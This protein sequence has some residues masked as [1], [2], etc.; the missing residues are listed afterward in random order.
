MAGVPPLWGFVAK[1]A[2][3]GAVLEEPMLAGM[4]RNLMLVG[5]VVGSILTMAYALRF[6]YGAFA[7]KPATHPTGG[8]TSEAVD[9]MHPIGPALWLAP[10]VLNLLTVVFGFWTHPLDHA[11]GT[12]LDNVTPL[13]AGAED[14]YLALWHGFTLP[15]LLTAIIIVAGV[16]MFWQRDVVAKAQ[17]EKPALGSADHGYDLVLTFFRNIS[18]RLTAST[19]RGSLGGNLGIIFSVLILLP[20]IALF[21]GERNDVRMVLWDSPGQAI[22]SVI[23]VLAAIAATITTN[24]LSGVILVGVTGYALAML[25]ACRAPLT[26]R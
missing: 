7:T 11:I 20:G 1:E 18:L 22:A 4:P 14:T 9:K 26:W 3:L 24:R 12:H 6:L 23:I 5:L 2:A 17:F 25:F 15:L 21:L 10:A 16:V 19:Q 8:G 13:P